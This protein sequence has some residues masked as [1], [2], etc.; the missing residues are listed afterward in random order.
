MQSGSSHF[1]YSFLYS[2]PIADSLYL[3]GK[4]YFFESHYSTSHTHL[5]SH[6]FKED[7]MRRACSMH[8]ADKKSY[9]IF[10]R[11]QRKGLRRAS[12]HECENNIKME[13]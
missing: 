2:L 1:L 3:T 7:E 13:I 9:E 5:T 10:I 8:G 4:T 11:T 12:R 6:D